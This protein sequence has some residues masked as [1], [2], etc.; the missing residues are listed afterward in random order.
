MLN[1]F[2]LENGRLKGGLVQEPLDQFEI[3]PNGPIWVDLEAPTDAEKAWITSR[4]GL[5]IPDDVADEDIE[6]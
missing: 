3:G 5:T 6:E 4:F 1:L 2:A